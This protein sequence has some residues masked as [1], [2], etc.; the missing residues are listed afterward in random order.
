MYVAHL[1]DIRKDTA[2]LSGPAAGNGA[3]GVYRRHLKR[4]FDLALVLLAAPFVLPVIAL[5]ALLVRRDGGPAFYSQDRVGLNGGLFRVW[6]L[7]S[8][9]VDAERVLPAYLEAN[10]AAMREW[11]T[12][13]K[14]KNDPRI[15]PVG[16]LLRKTSLDELPQLW[17]VLRGDMSLVGPRPM[18]PEQTSLYHGRAYYAMRPGLTGFWQISDRNAVSFA[19]RAEYD[20][21]Y[22]QRMSFVTDVLVLLATVWVVLRGTGY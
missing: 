5:F 17:N 2:V 11:A 7:R 21:L 22:S 10:P 13:Q 4:A 14:L 19:R 20:T 1:S 15:T 9:V 6:K 12:T 8:M 18:L 16:R 3:K